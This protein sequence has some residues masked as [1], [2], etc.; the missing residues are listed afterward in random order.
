MGEFPAG[1]VNRAVSSH[2]G[3]LGLARAIPTDSATMRLG[4]WCCSARVAK[5]THDE[6]TGES[7]RWPK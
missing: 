3:R 2:A 5:C 4:R 6:S 1:A 7:A